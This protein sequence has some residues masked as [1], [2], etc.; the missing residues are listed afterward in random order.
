MKSH[1]NQS[2]FCP[3]C[4]APSGGSQQYFSKN[5]YG[6]LMLRH[7]TDVPLIPLTI[8]KEQQALKE[9]GV[10]LVPGVNQAR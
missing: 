6:H 8:L 1:A 7:K 2:S 4:A 5:L 9:S 10:E 3:V